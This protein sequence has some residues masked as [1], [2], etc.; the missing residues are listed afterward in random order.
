MIDC[1][2]MSYPLGNGFWSVL[3]WKGCVVYLISMKNG[4]VS[5]V[6]YLLTSKFAQCQDSPKNKDIIFESR[7]WL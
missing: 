1:T 6:E 5:V 7:V 2:G 3:A 4:L